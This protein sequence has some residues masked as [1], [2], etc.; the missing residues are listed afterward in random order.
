MPSTFNAWCSVQLGGETVEPTSVMAAMAS[1]G[2]GGWLGYVDEI[3]MDEKMTPALLAM[4]GCAI[5]PGVLLP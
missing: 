2:D 1:V 5:K 4:A 3:E